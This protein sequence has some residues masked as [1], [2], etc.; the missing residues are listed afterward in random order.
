MPLQP[1]RLNYPIPFTYFLPTQD[2]ANQDVNLSIPILSTED[3]QIAEVIIPYSMFGENSDEAGLQ[4]LEVGPVPDSV[5]YSVNGSGIWGNSSYS[6]SVV[7]SIL[8]L[9]IPG[10]ILFNL[11]I[12]FEIIYIFIFLGSETIFS[13]QVKIYYINALPQ[14]TV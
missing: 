11:L 6:S 2:E 8:S 5:L 7:S 1:P 9:V 3:M 12:H 4:V 13:V 10:I 14:N